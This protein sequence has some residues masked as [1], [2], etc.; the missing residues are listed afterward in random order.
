MVWAALAIWFAAVVSTS[1]KAD[2]PGAAAEASST[3]PL[4]IE[5]I[6]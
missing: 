1:T 6:D 5:R 4:F 2:D 3:R